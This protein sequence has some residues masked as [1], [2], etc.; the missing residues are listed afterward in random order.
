MEK[1]MVML[2]QSLEVLEFPKDSLKL[3]QKASMKESE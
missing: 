1:A 2:Q 3:S